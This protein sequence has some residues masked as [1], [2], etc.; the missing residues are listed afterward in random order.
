MSTEI[1]E[2]PEQGEI[3]LATITKVMDHGAYVTLD[4]YNG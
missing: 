2:M 4:E 1:Q 3:V